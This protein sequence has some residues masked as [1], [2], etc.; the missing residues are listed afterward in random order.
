MRY[1]GRGRLP[2]S[3]NRPSRRTRRAEAAALPGMNHPAA[4]DIRSL[5]AFRRFRWLE[6]RSSH[7]QRR[8]NLRLHI[9]VI[10]SPGSLGHNPP[11]KR[12]PVVRILILGI[13][14]GRKRDALLQP[15]S[16]VRLGCAKLLV[17]PRI[18]FRKAVPRESIDVA[19]ESVL[20]HASA[21][22]FA[23]TPGSI[24]R[25]DHR[26]KVSLHHAASESRAT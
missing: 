3:T 7:L 26:A 19:P 9:L 8:K 4:V 17:P 15:R 14:Y 1:T 23:Q 13:R 25:P 16:E 12:E 6:S 18:V 5:A 11:E 21:S 10:T 2:W 22:P 24:S 20:R